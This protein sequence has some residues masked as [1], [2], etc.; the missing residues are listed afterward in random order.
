[1]ATRTTDPLE[2]WLS[3]KTVDLTTDVS[4]K[5]AFPECTD[6]LLSQTWQ[7]ASA[8]ASINAI[9]K[10]YFSHSNHIIFDNSEDKF[11]LSCPNSGKQKVQEPC[12]CCLPDNCTTLKGIRGSVKWWHDTTTTPPTIIVIDP[13]KLINRLYIA[14]VFWVFW[15]EEMGINKV[16]AKII[17]DYAIKGEFPIE[18]N[19]NTLTPGITPLIMESLTRQMKTG[20]ASSIKDRVSTYRR[21]L[22]WTTTVG[23]QMKVDTIVNS[24]FSEH[25]HKFISLAIDY[26]NQLRLSS[27]I[28]STTSGTASISTI[29]GIVTSLKLLQ[30]A[31][32]A[33]NYGR[34]YNNTLSAIVYCIASLDLIRNVKD[35]I[36]IPKTSIEEYVS[37]SYDVLIEGKSLS[38][39]KSERYILYKMLADYGRDLLLDI[40]CLN[41]G[42][43][44]DIKTWVENDVVESRVEAYRSAYQKLFGIDLFKTTSNLPQQA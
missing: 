12:T 2:I 22:G 23:R 27:A 28:Q 6:L 21:C 43:S 5:V 8:D 38:E 31:S 16:S 14:D 18:T 39:S 7:I 15:M 19:V 37:A 41:A 1:M 29:V 13:T 33:F 44:S 17:N 40:Q 25:F 10:E 35:K 36:G 3:E 34:N 24:S 20:L 11:K 30:E 26:Y 42:S 32:S 4:I 9:Y